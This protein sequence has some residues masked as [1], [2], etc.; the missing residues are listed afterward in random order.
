MATPELS[1]KR[2]LSTITKKDAKGKEVPKDVVRRM[3]AEAED[4]NNGVDRPLQLACIAAIVVPLAWAGATQEAPTA[5]E[6]L[7]GWASDSWTQLTDGK[8]TA[9]F[10]LAA[11]LLFIERL[12]Y[13]WVH[14]FSASFSRFCKSAVGQAMGGEKPL[15][16]VLK[17][18]WANKVIQLG[19]FTVW[20]F[21]VIDFASPFDSGFSWAGVTRLQWVLLAQG[22]ILD[23][24]QRIGEEGQHH[25]HDRAIL[26]H[27]ARA[28]I[29]QRGLVDGAG[30][31]AVAALH[32]I[33]VDLKL[34]LAEELAVLVQKQ[35]L[36]DLVAIG[37]L[38][39]WLDKDLALKNALGTV[40]EH[41]LEHLTAFATL[42]G[43][44]DEHGVV[45]V[46]ITA[47]RIAEHR[48]D[49]S[50]RIVADNVDTDS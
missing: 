48:G 25:Q 46:E 20:Y 38:R 10:Q 21:Y 23:F 34:R 22:L 19:T 40:L 31:R 15:D 12:C 32:V 29:E 14:T 47:I 43:V 42:G 11:A 16:V 8:L 2:R 30:G 37:F 39:P 9:S 4:P 6:Q 17:L 36:A 28:Q 5:G 49:M 18:F 24:F 35:R 3:E 26:R 50:H 33:G 13:T 1:P 41:F 45:M 44:G 7:S 27:A